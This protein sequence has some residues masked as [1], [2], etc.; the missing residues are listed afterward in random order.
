LGIQFAIQ[1]E[2]RGDLARY[3]VLKQVPEF[4]EKGTIDIGANIGFFGFSIAREFQSQVICVESNRNHCEF[5][6]LLIE[7]LELENVRV[8]E[9][10]VTLGSM[11]RLPEASTALVLNVLH[12]AGHDF[13]RDRLA[14]RSALPRYLAEW[15][16][17][18]KRKVEMA[19]VQVG[20]NWGGDNTQPIVEVGNR[21]E[22]ARLVVSGFAESGWLPCHVAFTREAGRG[23]RYEKATV[24]PCTGREVEAVLDVVRSRV[25]DGVPASDLQGEFN[26]RPIF[27][28]RK[29]S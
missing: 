27:W 12:H 11:E 20:Y 3:E 16:L 15:T 4:L 23:V 22:L 2:W 14:S 17:A 29:K 6:K 13:D 18:L 1:Q 19:V 24:P 7:L 10:A 9:E 8:I 26:K 28:F 5:M 25:A 21:V